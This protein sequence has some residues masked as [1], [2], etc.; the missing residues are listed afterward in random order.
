MGFNTCSAPLSKVLRGLQAQVEAPIQEQLPLQL[1]RV[2]NLKVNTTLGHINFLCRVCG[3][4]S[5][6]RHNHVWKDC[7]GQDSPNIVSLGQTVTSQ[8][9]TH[10]PAL[11]QVPGQAQAGLVPASPP[12]REGC[13]YWELLATHHWGDKFT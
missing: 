11:V 6:Y 7:I 3:N 5:S 4:G 9:Q 13:W 12:D 1:G 10:D 2:S 8:V